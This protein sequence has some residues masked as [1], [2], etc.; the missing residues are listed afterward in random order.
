MFGQ[1]P[2]K[3]HLVVL[4]G[5]FGQ[6]LISSML[7]VMVISVV[8]AILPLVRSCMGTFLSVL[9]FFSLLLNC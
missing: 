2:C 9:T 4:A 5:F 6:S 3:K 7:V 1:V 8:H